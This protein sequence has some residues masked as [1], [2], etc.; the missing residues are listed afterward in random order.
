[1]RNQSSTAWRKGPSQPEYLIIVS[2]V[3]S[4][5]GLKVD[6]VVSVTV[7]DFR[8]PAAG[9]SSFT[10]GSAMYVDSESLVVLMKVAGM[11]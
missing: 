7:M 3:Y 10:T 6:V 8:K 5:G 11:S 1:M 9:G 2:K 4:T